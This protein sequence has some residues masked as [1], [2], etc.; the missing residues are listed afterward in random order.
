MIQKWYQNDII[1][2]KQT[3]L[4]GAWEFF[5]LHKRDQGHESGT[6]YGQRDALLSLNRKSGVVT[7]NDTSP[8]GDELTDEPDIFVIGEGLNLVGETVFAILV[9]C[10]RKGL[11]EKEMKK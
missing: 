2:K 9:G 4:K 10:H 3:S 7:R 11:L 6:L 5:L 1:L 8:L